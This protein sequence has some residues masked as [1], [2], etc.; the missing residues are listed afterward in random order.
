[1]AFRKRRHDSDGDSD[2]ERLPINKDEDDDLKADPAKKPKNIWSDMLLEDQLLEKGQRINL[3]RSSR[4]QPNVSRGPESYVMP[5][6]EYNRKQMKKSSTKKP[7]FDNPV[8]LVTPAS[9]DL[10]GD[11][12]SALNE[13]FGVKKNEVKLPAKDDETGWWG[14]KGASRRYSDRMSHQERAPRPHF[15]NKKTSQL[16]AEE[17]SLETMLAAEFDDSV[18]IDELGNQI[19]AAMGEKDPDTVKKIV[20]AIGRELALK[21]FDETKE[22]EKS[23]GMKI[24]D[25]SRRRTPGGVFITLFK[26]DSTVSKE[27]KNGIFDNMRFADKQRSKQKKKAQNFTKQLEDVKKT[28]ELVAKAENDVANEELGISDDVPFSDDVVDMI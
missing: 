25:G 27:V 8:V 18:S 11:A 5:P 28:M 10:F 7:G 19:A 13:D 23:G 1:M 17:F 15:E 6:D 16:M 4:K 21:L 12:P 24:T 26:M 20:N 2:E 9:D 14:K 3:D 22:V